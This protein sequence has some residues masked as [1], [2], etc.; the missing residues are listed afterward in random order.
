MENFI[1]C[2][3]DVTFTSRCPLIL[4]GKVFFRISV[5]FQQSVCDG[6][7][8]KEKLRTRAWHQNNQ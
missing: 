6:I 5:N 7:Q 1:F 3:V 4:L 8:F 2:A